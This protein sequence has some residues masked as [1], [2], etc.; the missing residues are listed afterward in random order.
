MIAKPIGNIINVVELFDV[1][2]DRNAVAIIKLNIT[3]GLLVPIDFM[4]AN[5]IRLWRL[6][7]SIAFA[8][9]NAPKISNTI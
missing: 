9:K 8:T 1:H 4:V 6:F 5:A 3:F 7:V 2:I